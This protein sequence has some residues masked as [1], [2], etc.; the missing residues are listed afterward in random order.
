MEFNNFK[1]FNVTTIIKHYQLQAK[2]KN[3]YKQCHQLK[4]NHSGSNRSVNDVPVI[5]ALICT[6]VYTPSQITHR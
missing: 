2:K 1:A 3:V 6:C 4:A 5:T